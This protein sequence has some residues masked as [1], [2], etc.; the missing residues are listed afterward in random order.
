MKHQSLLI[1]LSCLWLSLIVLLV[2]ILTMNS[3]QMVYTI[4]D[5]YIHMAI[6]RNLNEFSVF[7]VTRHEFSSSSS[8]PL[9]NLIIC[10]GFALVGVNDMVPLALNVLLSTAA[11]VTMYAIL[12]NLDMSERY[13][14]AV[15][16]SF[17]FFTSLPGLVFTGMEH[18][19]HTVFSLVF[20]VLSTRIITEQESNV[21]Q[22]TLFMVVTFFVSA[23]RI[24]SMFLVIPVAILFLVKRRWGFAIAVLGMAALPWAVYG[25]VSMLNGWLPLPNSLVVKGADAIAQGLVWFLV[26]GIGSLIV[27]PHLLVLLMASIKLTADQAQEPWTTGT[28][29]KWV[30]ISACI[31]HLQLGK[32]GWFF[33][34]EAYLVALGILTLSI[35]GHRFFSKLTLDSLRAPQID[36]GGNKNRLYGLALIVL[37]VTPLAA[38][39]ALWMYWTPIASTNIHDQHYEMARFL[40]EFYY[41]EA[42]MLNDIGYAN[43]LTDIVCVDKWGLA[44]LDIGES[45]LNGSMSADTLRSI[46][47]EHGVKIA[48]IYLDGF[49]PEEWEPVGHWTI[50]NNVVAYN[51]TI[52]FLVVMPSERDRLISSLQLFSPSLPDDVIESGTYTEMTS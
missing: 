42:V 44:T 4:D 31:L 51:S 6:S 13:I 47:S 39:G 28:V 8:S 12:R 16:V 29:M 11:V 7:G 22:L 41:G 48:A 49:I 18:I 45:L 38:R 43:Y 23:A 5:I 15:L 40:D 30:F 24:E 10:A 3:G 25:I 1:A 27:S 37:F 9:W 50:R 46:A 19:L 34:Y 52:S 21:Q 20:I 17:V 33:R 32:I 36:L 14:T 2:A 35:Q 26:R